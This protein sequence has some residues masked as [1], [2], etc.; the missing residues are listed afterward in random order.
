MT[1]VDILYSRAVNRVPSKYPDPEVFHPERFLEPTWPTYQEPLTRYPNLTDG[2]GMH[3]F[4]WG[5]R[6]C[7]GQ[8]IA[9][10]ELFL[11]AACMLWGFDLAPQTCPL[12]GEEVKFDTQATNSS[13]ILESTPFPMSIAPRSEAKSRQM[14]AEYAEVRGELKFG[15]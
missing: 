4:G 9:D 2:F 11:A 5:R 7:L 8:S 1:H 15:S 10:H 14:L 12:T 3:T 6:V 13:V